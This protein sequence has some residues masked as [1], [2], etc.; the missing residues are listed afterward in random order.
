MIHPMLPTAMIRN[1]EAAPLGGGIVSVF[2]VGHAQ[3]AATE[4]TILRRRRS[5]GAWFGCCIGTAKRAGQYDDTNKRISGI[6]K[7][8]WT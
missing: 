3:A 5:W 1:N 4:R 7:E 2:H 8:H 6:G